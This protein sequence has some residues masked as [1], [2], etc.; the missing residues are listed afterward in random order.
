VNKRMDRLQSL[1]SPIEPIHLDTTKLSSMIVGKKGAK[2]VALIDRIC[3]SIDMNEYDG[4]RERSDIADGWAVEGEHILTDGGDDI[5]DS[6]DFK[7]VEVYFK[8]Y[9]EKEA[10][11]DNRREFD[12][13]ERFIKTEKTSGLK[14]RET[15]R[16]L[17]ASEEVRISA[18]VA[19]LKKCRLRQQGL[20]DGQKVHQK[21]TDAERSHASRKVAILKAAQM[22]T[23]DC[24]KQFKRVR[25]FFQELHDNRK[26]KLRRQCER[27]LKIQ[28]VLHRLRRT[29]PRVMALERNTAERI[30]RKKES[31]MVELNMVQNLEEATY[32]ERIISLLDDVQETK[33]AATDAYFKLQI[34]HLRHQQEED[35]KRSDEVVEMNATSMLEMA[36]LIAK[37]VKEEFQDREDDEK[38][39]DHVELTERKKDF[40]A[41]SSN[42]LLS[43]SDLY[44]TI[45]WSVATGSIG[46]SSS[47]NDSF[48]SYDDMDEEEDYVHDKEQ[49]NNKKR[50]NSPNS[51]NMDCDMDERKMGGNPAEDGG[52]VEFNKSWNYNNSDTVSVK[53]GS[54]A[55]TTHSAD[56]NNGFS[57]VGHMFVKKLRKQIREKELKMEK[58]HIA[59]RKRGRRQFRADARKL[60]EKHQAIVDSIL[61]NCVDERHKLRD[62]IAYRM[63][64]MEEKQTLSTQT[65]QEAI[66]AD[67]KAMQGAWVEHTRLEEEQKF[68][69]AKAQALISAQVFH[70]VRNAL[71][72]VVAMSEM[73]SSLQED[74]TVTSETLV[75]SVGEMLEQNKE[76]VNYS[77]NMLNN[78]LDVSKIKAGSFEIKKTFFDLQDLVNRATTMQLVKAQ[79][80]GVKMS[81]TPMPEPQIAYTD[82]DIVTRIITNFI[83][84]AVKFTTAGAVQPFICPL[85]SISPSK[86]NSIQYCLPGDTEFKQE[87]I[88]RYKNVLQSGTKFVAV[89]VADTG[90]GLSRELLHIAEAGLFSSDTSSINSGAK[91]SGF[92]LHLAHQLASTL[93][94][95]VNLTDLD[96]FQD[97]YNADM[98][99]VLNSNSSES[100]SSLHGSTTS[101]MSTSDTGSSAESLAGSVYSEDSPGKGAVLY[102]IIPVLVDGEQGKAIL[103]PAPDSEQ[104]LEILSREFIFS[105]RPSPNAADGCFRILVAD[106]VPMLRKGLMRS[107]L[108]IFTEFTDC[109]I[110]VSTACTA[111]DALRAVRSRAY[112][113]FICDNQFAPPHHLN[114]LSPGIEEMR[115]EVHKNKDKNLVRK[116][117]TEFFS[118]E[119]F[120][121]APGDGYLSG[122]D[123]LLQLNQSKDNPYPIPILVLHSGHQLE[124]PPQIGVIIVRKPLKRIDFMPL[125]ERNAQNLIDTGMCHEIQIG[126]EKVVLN[127]GGAQLFRRRKQDI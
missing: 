67:V 110:A 89:G 65:L 49:N 56:S 51:S 58:A 126:N 96:T 57:P 120:T 9:E 82:E 61:A 48:D 114:R 119:A 76:V 2:F 124:L 125:F 28:S 21:I 87:D 46:L 53:S 105:P 24:R 95:R 81:F 111:E 79:A 98:C 14:R 44:D 72:S 10:Q 20:A 52:F 3:T 108:D 71:S 18:E 75:S 6:V 45:L 83:S 86:K 69:F 11:I 113:M 80:R 54:T 97:L 30:F 36:E 4:D 93:G 103:Q 64:K 15:A 84:N 115:T 100:D 26:K 34:K 116:S 112:D 43:V 104:G 121:I 27:S 73:T 13:I 74:P 109:P 122:L 118:Q 50:K 8:E 106:D 91:N 66:D 39:K 7:Q 94:S 31:D 107:V 85:E 90:P 37:Y 23:S 29:D 101:L 55:N 1:L 127:K 62:A 33:E 70:E 41:T 77:L 68:S 47:D 88:S 59:E 123:A 17:G 32:L 99:S 102:I 92:G 42:V 117:V 35:T 19:E 16:L 78:I 25:D 5:L 63:E 38:T 60:K 40:Q 12:V 22:A